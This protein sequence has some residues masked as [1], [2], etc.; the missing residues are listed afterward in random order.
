[1]DELTLPLGA[2]ARAVGVD[3]E[4]PHAILLA[5][6]TYQQTFDVGEEPRYDSAAAT[7]QRS[8]MHLLESLN[9]SL[10]SASKKR[11]RG[12]SSLKPKA[13][14]QEAAPALAEKPPDFV[15][16]FSDFQPCLAPGYGAEGIGASSRA[17]SS[18]RYNR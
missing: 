15:L 13:R 10:W 14:L 9:C 1:M 17:S 7:W 4:V 3:R 11:S 2:F 6:S 16:L 8:I 18:D 12:F 5:N